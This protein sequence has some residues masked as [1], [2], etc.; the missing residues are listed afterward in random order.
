VFT[1]IVEAVGTIRAVRAAG[2]RVRLSVSLGPVAK[3][4][5]AGDSV[6]VD[7][8]CLT[9]VAAPGRGVGTFDCVRETLHRTALG[10]LRPGDRVNLE[11][12]LRLGDR[13]GG[14]LV[15]GHAD[16]VGLVRANGGKAGA[17]TLSVAA[18]PEVRPYLAPKGSVAVDGVSLTLASVDRE[19]FIA[20]LV[21]HTLEATTLR[22]LRV[23]EA[24]NLEADVLAKWV[25]RLL[26]EAGTLRPPAA[27]PAPPEPRTSGRGTPRR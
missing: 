3:G 1:G 12:A 9:L 7:G 2:E 15:Q 19:G 27:T 14:H 8:V 11:G 21:P 26:E 18:P 10:R 5:R 6:A 20:A 24:V 4:A 25:R 16:G 17:W 22:A 13:L 23:G